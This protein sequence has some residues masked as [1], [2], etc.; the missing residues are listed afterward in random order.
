MRKILILFL[1]V[2]IGMGFF[3]CGSPRTPKP[4][5]EIMTSDID[6][7]LR[8]VDGVIRTES[9]S[10]KTGTLMNPMISGILRAN[11]DDTTELMRILDDAHQAILPLVKD[12]PN[13]TVH[14]TVIGP[15]GIKVD[16][17]NVGFPTALP[18]FEDLAAHYE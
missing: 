2:I 1:T 7:A 15:S 14:F 3:G 6:Y 10:Y 5:P 12:G 11:T 16:A 4:D 8:N 18:S 17:L 13:G 9:V